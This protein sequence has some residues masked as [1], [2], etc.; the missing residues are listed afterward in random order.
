M[1]TTSGP[2]IITTHSYLA[3]L[4]DSELMVLILLIRLFQHLSI[5]GFLAVLKSGLRSERNLDKE[6]WLFWP[7][8]RAQFKSTCPLVVALE[9]ETAAIGHV[10]GFGICPI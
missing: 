10:S 3:P 9:D 1:T 2:G 5:F 4:R 6:I 7:R 8:S